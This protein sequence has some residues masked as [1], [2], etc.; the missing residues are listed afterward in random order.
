MSCS[1]MKAPPRFT[2]PVT[3]ASRVKAWHC[4]AGVQVKQLNS[5]KPNEPE[6]SSK[7]QRC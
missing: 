4:L 6:D 5:V 3:L 7:C 2:T 1:E